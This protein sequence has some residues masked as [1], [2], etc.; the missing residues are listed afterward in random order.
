MRRR[1]LH[2]TDEE[3][4]EEPLI[5]L[6]PLIDVVFVVLIAFM[7]I[8]PVLDL[9]LVQLAP[10]G[11]GN[12]MESTNSIL[13]ITLKADNTIW[14]R[15]KKVNITELEQLLKIA[16]KQNPSQIPQLIPD[17]QAQ[18]GAYQS[19]KN[20]LESCGFDQMDIVLQPQ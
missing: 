1:L 20:V 14:Y 3:S 19:I 6:T 7:L 5:N 4:L 8:A 12:K 9:D 16:K 10:G 13:A 17:K 15:Q 11:K 2:S 18:F